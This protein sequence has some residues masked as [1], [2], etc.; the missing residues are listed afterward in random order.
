MSRRG[1]KGL[2][3][4]VGLVLS[5]ITSLGG[6]E[7]LPVTA[8]GDDFTEDRLILRSTVSGFT[9]LRD[10][11]RK[12]GLALRGTKLRV[13]KDVDPG[14]GER[15]LI[16]TIETV[17]CVVTNELTSRR[18]R[19]HLGVGGLADCPAAAEEINKLVK[20]DEAYR[21]SKAQLEKHG[22]YRSGWVYGGLMVP[23]KY[24][25][26]DKSFSSAVTIGPYLGYRLGGFGFD[27]AFVGTLGIASLA[28][29]NA[30]GGTS[31][32]QGYTTALGIIG[33]V[34]KNKNPLQLGILI[35][36][37]WAGSNSAIRYEHEG[38]TWIAAQIGFRFDK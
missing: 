10:E 22:F 5:S 3:T 4:V 13:I 34:T 9:L 24:H 25:R 37:D 19:V 21:I 18:D 20:T 17:P 38:K 29:A 28:V 1:C 32:Q 16:V 26:H 11:N 12:D 14:N 30:S 35:G 15:E 27:T 8:S 2:V 33:S 23:Y 36:R 31:T 7:S 6:A